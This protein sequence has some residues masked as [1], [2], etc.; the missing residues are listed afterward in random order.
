LHRQ[1]SLLQPTSDQVANDIR[2]EA[3]P[4]MTCTGRDGWVSDLATLEI[5]RQYGSPHFHVQKLAARKF[6]DDVSPRR[7]Q[8]YP[9][10]RGFDSHYRRPLVAY[11]VISLS[12]KIRS[13][14]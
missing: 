6:Y 1:L 7:Y 11:R 10:C 3:K 13:L 12:R 5:G 9:K 8:S 2:V 4:T 14:L